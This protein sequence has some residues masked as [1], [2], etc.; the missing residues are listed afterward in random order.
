[1][2]AS[3]LDDAVLAAWK[4][5]VKAANS[6]LITLATVVSSMSSSKVP[7]GFGKV[8]LPK[9]DLSGRKSSAQAFNSSTFD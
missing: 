2:A 4:K 8:D 3:K 6:E 5:D 1:M 9:P 7:M